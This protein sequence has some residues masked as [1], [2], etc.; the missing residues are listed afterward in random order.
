MTR[1]TRLRH[2]TRIEARLMTRDIGLVASALLVPMLVLLGWGS[3]PGIREASAELGGQRPL[4]ALIAPIAVTLAFATLALFALPTYLASYRENGL[5][6]RL[7]AT[8]V[9]AGTL[10]VA[11]LLAN[12]VL[13][14][15][16]TTLAIGGGAV[17]FGMALPGNLVGFVGSVLLGMTAMFSVGLLVAAVAPTTSAAS[18]IST[19]L[20]FPLMLLGGLFVP[21]EQLPDIVGTVGRFTPLGAALQAVRDS[22]SGAWPEPRHLAVLG[23]TTFIAG[24]L[25]AR[26]FRWE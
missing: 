3:V 23:V 18:G 2:L 7:Q 24:L 20:F 9:G 14:A 17:I 19:M 6:R 15:A 26:W 22:W 4:E 21:L 1:M 16:A 12:A 13:S 5:L 8:P 25:A 11:H 10:L